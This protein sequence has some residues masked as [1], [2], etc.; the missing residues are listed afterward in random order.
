[1]GI[2]GGPGARPEPN[3]QVD[4]HPTHQAP[5]LLYVY[6]FDVQI[7]A[8]SSTVAKLDK[9]DGMVGRKITIYGGDPADWTTN[10]VD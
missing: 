6:D 4:G 9:T 5:G 10:P 7:T 2:S 3:G 8:S 1:V